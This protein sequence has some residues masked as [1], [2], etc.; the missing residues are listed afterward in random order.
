MFTVGRTQNYA[1]MGYFCIRR[2]VYKQKR[3]ERKFPLYWHQFLKLTKNYY[4]WLISP[5][6]WGINPKR[7]ESKSRLYKISP[8]MYSQIRGRLNF[9]LSALQCLLFRGSK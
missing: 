9:E 5:T 7:V 1:E 3:I 2:F 6:Y 4:Y 8:I